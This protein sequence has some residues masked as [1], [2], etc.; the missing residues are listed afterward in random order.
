MDS[1]AA[2]VALTTEGLLAWGPGSVNPVP[3]YPLVWLDSSGKE[4]APKGEPIAGPFVAGRVSLD[5]Q[6][7]L[8]SFCYPGWEAEVLDLGRR[9]RRRATFDSNPMWA[10]WGPGPDRITFTSDREGPMGLYTRRLDAGP[11]VIE[12]L[13]KTARG[14]EHGLGL[15][16]WSRDGKVLAF[17][18]ISTLTNWD[19]WILERG[20][21][22]RPFVATPF[23]E[24]HPDI[25]PDGQWLLYT[26]NESGRREVFARAL[27]G[28]GGALQVSNGKGVEPLWSR[29]GTN[30]F[31]W[32][33]G[34]GEFRTLFRVSVTRNADSLKFGVPE[35]LLEGAYGGGAPGHGWDVA[36]DGRFLVNKA[37]DTAER[38]A[39][40]DK[41]LSN[42]IVVDTGGV[43]RLLADARAGP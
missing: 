9:A 18:R 15:G 20:K 43:A 2:Q 4:T 36:P 35:R 19:I 40:W 7:V 11:D 17:A 3:R 6:R 22:P 14:S 26:S 1:G 13:W 21:E 37:G 12:T 24:M 29:D 27:S 41:L 28:D 5:G 33:F 23:Y 31:Y 8:L 16:S 30:V 38:R 39:N 10:I 32:V 34:K 42:R 25:S